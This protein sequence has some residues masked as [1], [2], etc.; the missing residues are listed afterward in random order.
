VVKPSHEDGDRDYEQ[1][2]DGREDTVGGDH[3]L[4]ADHVLKT[5]THAWRVSIPSRSRSGLHIPL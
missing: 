4:V 2:G 1:E 3:S 5:I